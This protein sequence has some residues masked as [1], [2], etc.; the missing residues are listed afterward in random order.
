MGGACNSVW[1]LYALMPLT[2]QKHMA[3]GPGPTFHFKEHQVDKV[4]ISTEFETVIGTS[5]SNTDREQIVENEMSLGAHNGHNYAQ[6]PVRDSHIAIG[7]WLDADVEWSGCCQYRAEME[8]G[9]HTGWYG[10]NPDNADFIKLESDLVIDGVSVTW[11]S[12]PSES[13]TSSNIATYESEPFNDEWDAGYTYDNAVVESDSL[14]AIHQRDN[15]L[16]RIENTDYSIY[17][18][19]D[20]Y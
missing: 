10:Y 16:V 3:V 19:V 6:T 18:S 17:V 4:T 12:P 15:G 2:V 5:F 20:L 13:S 8:G 7:D 1:D 9:Q 11:S 14:S